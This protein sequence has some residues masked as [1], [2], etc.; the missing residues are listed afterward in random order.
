MSPWIC[1]RFVLS[2]LP[3]ERS[4]RVDTF[5]P[6]RVDQSRRCVRLLSIDSHHAQPAAQ[7]LHT[8]NRNSI[9]P[10]TDTYIRTLNSYAIPAGALTG[11][12]AAANTVFAGIESRYN[13]AVLAA[14]KATQRPTVYAGMYWGTSW[15]PP[16]GDSYVANMLGDA[17]AECV[18]ACNWPRVVSL[19]APLA[20]TNSADVRPPPATCC[21]NPS[22]T[23]RDR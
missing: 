3:S 9:I 4:G 7:R 1:A 10:Q 23:R 22:T 11:A 6:S 15:Y 17:A 20:V 12:E 13:A 19:L 16:G 14:S 2:Q 21:V 5:G 8:G 18:L